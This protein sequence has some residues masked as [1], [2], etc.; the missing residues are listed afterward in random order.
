MSV[1][2]GEKLLDLLEGPGLISREVCWKAADH[3]KRIAKINADLLEAL[4]GMVTHFGGQDN[5]TVESYLITNTQ[6][7]ENAKA[8][9]AKARGQS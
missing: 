2:S 7:L 6:A 8:A 5:R 4:E 9:I 1:D 3:M